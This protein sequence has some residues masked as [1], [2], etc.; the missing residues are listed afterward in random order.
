MTRGGHLRKWLP[1]LGALLVC[2]L[3]LRLGFWQLDRA[4]Q[5]ETL[6]AQLSQLR[7][8]PPVMLN[9]TPAAAGMLEFHPTQANGTWQPER[10]VLLDNQMHEGRVGF[11]VYMPLKIDGSSMHVLVNR[12]WVAGNPD[13]HQLPVI[14]TPAGP[15]LVVGFARQNPPHFSTIAGI[16]RENSVWSEISIKSFADWSGLALQPVMLYQTSEAADGLQRNWPNPGSGADRNRGYAF[17]WFALAAM[18][19]IFWLVHFLRRR[20]TESSPNVE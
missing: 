1:L 15:Q 9:A 17:Q 16:S 5:R 6:D 10:L 18:T 20:R 13:R 12:G 8:S 11:H 4:R 19:A 7:A 2:G 3:T 14:A